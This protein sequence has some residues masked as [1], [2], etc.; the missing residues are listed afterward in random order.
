MRG[1]VSPSSARL[2]PEDITCCAAN[3]CA[4]LT[5]S[6]SAKNEESP[7][8]QENLGGSDPSLRSPIDRRSLPSLI[9][10]G[11]DAD[12]AVEEA[13]DDG[14]G[15]RS[16]AVPEVQSARLGHACRGDAPADDG[17]MALHELP[18]R[19]VRRSAQ[20]GPCHAATRKLTSVRNAAAIR[21]SFMFLMPA[22]RSAGSVTCA[23][24]ERRD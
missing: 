4:R 1:R 16:T 23:D 13:S 3:L 18:T 20:T 8:R 19:M 9:G 12:R 5:R 24:V 10:R 7:R 15:D 2:V 17:W 21:H 6:R 14:H 22:C 11:I